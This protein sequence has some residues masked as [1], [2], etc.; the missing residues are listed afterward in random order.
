MSAIDV[1]HEKTGAIA[2]AAIAAAA[3][4]ALKKAFEEKDEPSSLRTDLLEAA[5][6]ERARGQSLLHT[7]LESAPHTLLP[8]LDHATDAA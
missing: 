2:T 7:L 1:T 8:L 3:A 6:T 5:T 4:Y